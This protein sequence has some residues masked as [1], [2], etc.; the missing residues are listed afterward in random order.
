VKNYTHFI[1]EFTD[2][3]PYLHIVCNHT[4]DVIQSHGCISA[5]SQQGLEHTHKRHKKIWREAT[6]Q[7][8]TQATKQLFLHVLRETKFFY[9][10]DNVWK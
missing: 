10:T 3:T 2:Y 9:F 4:K 7:H 5:I 8:N 6:S 1:T